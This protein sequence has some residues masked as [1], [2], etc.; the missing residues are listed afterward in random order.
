[1][2]NEKKTDNHASSAAQGGGESSNQDGDNSGTGSLL[3]ENDNGNGGRGS[4]TRNQSKGRTGSINHKPGDHMAANDE[5]EDYD[6]EC[7]KNNNQN[8]IIPEVAYTFGSVELDGKKVNC[9]YFEK[10]AILLFF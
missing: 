4:I 7:G 8:D 3:N 10:K 6:I 9:V 2:S 5:I 1:M